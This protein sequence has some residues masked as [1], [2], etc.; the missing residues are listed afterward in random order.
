MKNFQS[1]LFVIFVAG[2][3]LGGF[4]TFV[5]LLV[6]DGFVHAFRYDE[7]AFEKFFLPIVLVGGAVCGSYLAIA[8]WHGLQTQWRRKHHECVRCGYDL[9]ATPDRCPECGAVVPR[10]QRTRIRKMLKE[11]GGP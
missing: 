4:G 2:F 11:A 8:K 9:R 7:R 3:L 6:V 5:G 1:S 10:K